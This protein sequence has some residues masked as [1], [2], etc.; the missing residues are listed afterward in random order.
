VGQL[1]AVPEPLA[2]PNPDAR[3]ARWVVPLAVIC[4]L[5]LAVT[6]IFLYTNFAALPERIPTHY[7]IDGRADAY[8]AKSAPIVAMPLV[9]GVLVTALMVVLLYGI[10]CGTR[11]A[12][13]GE[14]LA[15]RWG[16]RRI[17]GGSLAALTVALNLL[18][19]YLAVSPMVNP[20]GMPGGP[21]VLI[22]ILLAVVALAFWMAIK[23]WDASGGDETPEDRWTAGL[24]Y[25]N[26][27]DPALMV[28]RRVG[29]GYTPNF[30]R[31]LG[32]VIIL[33]ALALAATPFVLPR[34]G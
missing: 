3:M 13:E 1:T 32:W 21:G 20:Q 4:F 27:N 30:A 10:A 11:C 34:L 33:L 12:G 5:L 31:P 14:R 23:L 7:G 28:E 17:A 8:H 9:M 6:A 24:F 19:S 26:P 29:F 15:R 25:S 2:A 16:Q 18:F 22:G